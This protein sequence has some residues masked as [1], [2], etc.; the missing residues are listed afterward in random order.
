M[1]L[2][3]CINIRWLQ[4]GRH[5]CDTIVDQAFS[6]GFLAALAMIEYQIFMDVLVDLIGE[7]KSLYAV[8]SFSS[9]AGS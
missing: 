7:K 5:P 1:L 6:L 4:D 3:E 8:V 2:N 9:Q